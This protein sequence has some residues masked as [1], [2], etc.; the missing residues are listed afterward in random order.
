MGS[1]LDERRPLIAV[2]GVCASGKS[3]LVTGLRELGFNARQVLQEHSYVPYMWQRIT[4]PDLL[5]YLDCSIETTRA[6]RRDR[7]FEVWLLEEE[8]HR[9]R[10]ALEHCDLYIATDELSPGEI[11]NRAVAFLVGRAP[12]T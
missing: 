3:T 6:R 5:I 9:L 1:R 7:D 12:G 10:H 11:L 2:V 4:G 8:R